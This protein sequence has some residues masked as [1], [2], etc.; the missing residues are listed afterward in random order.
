MCG[1]HIKAE[2]S[3]LHRVDASP[4]PILQ[5]GTC[6]SFLCPDPIRNLSDYDRARVAIVLFPFEPVN[7]RLVATSLDRLAD[8]ASNWSPGLAGS[9]VRRVPLCDWL[10]HKVALGPDGPCPF[11]QS[12]SLRSS[13]QIDNLRY[14]G[15]RRVR[16]R[17][18]G[19]IESRCACRSSLPCRQPACL[20]HEQSAAVCRLSIQ[21]TSRLMQE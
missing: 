1:G 13:R 4:K 3:A 20:R 6:P 7:N 16:T 17:T 2:Y 11:G 14:E 12:L 5:P 10:A 19:S 15:E 8:L 9:T 18:L 21:A